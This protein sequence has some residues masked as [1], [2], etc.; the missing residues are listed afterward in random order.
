[1]RSSCGMRALLAL[2]AL[3]MPSKSGA[4]QSLRPPKPGILAI[5]SAFAHPYGSVIWNSNDQFVCGSP[6]ADLL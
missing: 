4:T 2:A 1:M 5:S 3:A 6:H